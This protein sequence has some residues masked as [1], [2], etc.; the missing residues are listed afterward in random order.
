MEK[1]TNQTFASQFCINTKCYILCVIFAVSHFRQSE[2]LAVSIFCWL[3]K[4]SSYPHNPVRGTRESIRMPIVRYDVEPIRAGQA[5][6]EG[7]EVC[8]PE[9]ERE[10]ASED[11]DSGH[12]EAGEP[13]PVAPREHH[14]GPR[15]QG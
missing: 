12:E 5:R 9:E 3:E 15:D 14:K 2:N 8:E 4:S 1:L 13:A 6:E 10:N 11:G 7:E